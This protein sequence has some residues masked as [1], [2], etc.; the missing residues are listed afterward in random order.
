MRKLLCLIIFLIPFGSLLTQELDFAKRLLKL[1]NTNIWLEKFDEASNLVNRAKQILT[2]YNTWDAKY[3]DAVA[4][5]TLGHIY[6]QMGVYDF[7]ETQFSNA[8]EKYRKLVNSNYPGSQIKMR[9]LM[10]KTKKE[11]E[12]NKTELVSSNAKVINLSYTTLAGYLN[13]PEDLVSFTAVECNLNKFPYELYGKKYLKV[14]ALKGNRINNAVIREIPALEYLD[15]SENNLSEL[16]IDTPTVPN[17]KYLDLSNNRLKKIPVEILSLKK[18]NFID[19]TNNNIP[20]SEIANLI[21]NLPNTLVLYDRYELI[22]E[23]EE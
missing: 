19:L 16:R 12:V 2:K 10:D 13:L 8:Y 14:L 7:A 4:D 23:E 6:L 15:L 17:L 20:F 5:E 11:K 21:Q 1:A 3:W 22:E 18:L 9:D